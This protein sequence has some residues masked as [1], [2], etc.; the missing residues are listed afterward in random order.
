MADR[1]V[2]HQCPPGAEDGKPG[3]AQ[4]P[5]CGRWIQET[6]LSPDNRMTVDPDLVTCGKEQRG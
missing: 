6:I 1:A 5:C 4:F 2:V 3:S